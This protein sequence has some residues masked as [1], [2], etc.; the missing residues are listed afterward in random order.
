MIFLQSYDINTSHAAKI[1]KKYKNKSI[2]IIKENPY[3]LAD[4]I[5]R[6]GF[7]TADSIAMKIGIDKESYIRCRSGVLYALN[8]LSNEGHCF[9]DFE[10]LIETSV[11]LLD[12]EESKIVMTISHMR[13]QKEIINESGKHYLPS[14]YFSE[15]GVARLI[16][17]IMSF[18]KKKH[19][20][21]VSFNTK[22]S[23]DETQ[24]KSIELAVNSKFIIITGGP[25]TGKT[26]TMNGIIN[27]LQKNNLDIILAAPTGRAAKRMTESS[28]LVSRTIHRLLEVSSIEGYKRNEN[29]QLHGN[30][31]IIDESSM[32][33][34]VLMYNLLKAVPPHMSIILI[35]DKD[36]LPSVE[37]GNTFYDLIESG[38]IPI[39]KLEKIY[40]Q[41]ANSDIIKNA[42]KINIGEIPSLKTSKNS[43]FF[44]MEQENS[45]N[46]PQLITEL[47]TKRLPM[48][49]KINP[50]RDIQVL[51]PM[52]KGD[53]GTINLNAVL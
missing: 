9:A 6:I 34:I 3:Q 17:K 42:H 40:W 12:I 49:Y 13:L 7:K 27:V 5:T 26:T 4:D 29:N 36:Q 1:F 10:Q 15:I 38:T 21:N 20:K 30:V 16:K 24:K 11:R 37:P 44:F 22:V 39:V 43:D 8:E 25:G 47:C 48:T 23:Y 35:G 14:L 46:I 53:A 51:C 18:P 41:A 2:P 33:D 31:L 52:Q 32:V 19:I 45:S 28:G 50:L